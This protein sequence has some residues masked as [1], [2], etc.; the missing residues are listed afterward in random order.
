[1]ARVCNESGSGVHG[2]RGRCAN[3]RRALLL[4]ASAIC[5]MLTGPAGPVAAA[6]LRPF[7]PPARTT[8]VPVGPRDVFL[9]DHPVLGDRTLWRGPHG[10]SSNSDEVTGVAA[11]MF[12]LDWIADPQIYF[13]SSA[14]VDRHGNLYAQPLWPGENVLLVS[15]DGRT[16]ARRFSI[17][18]IASQSG[19][20]VPF[21]TDDPARCGE[22]IVFAAQRSGAVAL[23]TDGTVLW[24]QP[25]GL[26][27]PDPS[28]PM[29][30]HSIG[31]YIQFGPNYHPGA[32]ALFTVTG[33]GIIV[34][35]DRR[36]GALVLESPYSLPGEPAPA[37]API[38][39]P[40]AAQAIL[41]AEF[42]PLLPG[43]PSGAGLTEIV[44]V[45][46][47][48]N[49]E[50]ANFF[51][52]DPRTG[53]MWIGATAPDATD[54]TID[55]V[56]R[57]GALYGLDVE[58]TGTGRYRI[59]EACRADFL[60]GTGTT[61]SLN[62]DGSRIY[63]A[64]ATGNLL[65]VDSSCQIVW[66]FDVGDQIAGS[67]SVSQ[68]NH[69][70]YVMAG[71][72]VA[73]LVDRG[74]HAELVW[75]STLDMYALDAGE[76]AY[77]LLTIGVTANGLVVQAGAGTVAVRPDGSETRRPRKVGTGLLDR[78]TG[79]VRWFVEGPEESVAT[80]P[81]AVDGSLFIPHSPI[82]RAFTRALTPSVT[83]PLMGGISKYTPT[84]RDLLVRDAACA[85]ADRTARAESIRHDQPQG[86]AADVA[87]VRHLIDQALAA[88]PTA[89]AD[90]E[91][92]AETWRSIA[93]DLRRARALIRVL[94]GWPPW[95]R[96][97][98]RAEGLLRNACLA[99]PG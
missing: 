65:A 11:P 78:E 95:G 35:Y 34:G 57:F 37:G 23:R 92:G 18:G 88:G 75:R 9:D 41:D 98:V 59:V 12:S 44:A 25:S 6:T 60:G 21:L 97:L 20:G 28:E 46:L 29:S 27:L 7:D 14:S 33:D 69:E 71:R 50:V 81:I 48:Q 8:W 16:G 40:P 70:L 49:V 66:A 10:N 43:R 61:P 36:T 15:Y 4:F 94:H 89:V 56:S 22:Q 91:L 24:Q 3:W 68:D 39:V 30:Q 51:S 31:E 47:G 19:A 96:S 76:V 80:T 84:R 17:P 5:P 82:R 72:D 55:G 58:P 63:L 79:R 83:G 85:A 64:D 99:L 42:L 62:G 90:G 1:M 53:R 45:L 86:T 52:I 32:D 54:G 13:A 67:P 87:Q 77:N 38:V 93:K 73:K 2:R 26:A 74:D